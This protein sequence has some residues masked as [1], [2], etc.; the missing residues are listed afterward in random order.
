ML[1]LLPWFVIRNLQLEKR[2]KIGLTFA[3]SLGAITGVI[4]ILRTFFQFVQ[5][6]YN[7]STVPLTY[8]Y[9]PGANV[10][11]ADYIVFML[12][13]NFLEPAATIIAQTIPIFRVLLVRARRATQR[14]KTSGIHTYQPASDVELVP[15]K[16][17]SLRR[18][19]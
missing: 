15:V 2:E 12:L 4:V 13:F 14:S 16:S 7:Y 18:P 19:I 1:A 10:S 9:Q 6:D 11:R 8:C 3:M 5:G 17:N